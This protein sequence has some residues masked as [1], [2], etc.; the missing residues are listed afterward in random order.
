MTREQD[1]AFSDALLAL[2]E[3]QQVPPHDLV[4]LLSACVGI[5]IATMIPAELKVEVSQTALREIATAFA[6]GTIRGI[7]EEPSAGSALQ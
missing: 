7:E 4:R 1:L 6:A 5:V 3:E 2:A